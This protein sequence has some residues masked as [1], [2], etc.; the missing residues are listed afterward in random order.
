VS[1]DGGRSWSEAQLG[2]EPERSS[3]WRAWS[4]EWNAEP[5]EHEL[6]VRA[7][8]EAGNVQ[9]DEPP[10]NYGGFMNNTVQRVPVLVR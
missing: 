2:P 6:A 7:T 9:P 10:W 8:D 4:F 1:T 3:T 5:G